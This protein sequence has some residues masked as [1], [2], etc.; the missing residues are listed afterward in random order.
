MLSSL[1]HETLRQVPTSLYAPPEGTKGP[2]PKPFGLQPAV[3][4]ESL[5]VPETY[6]Q[7]Q[8]FPFPNC[9]LGNLQG[10]TS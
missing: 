7:E 5:L 8:A 4:T 10:L 6:T 2:S 9:K 1:P 3:N